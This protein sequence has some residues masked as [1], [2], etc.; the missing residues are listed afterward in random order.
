MTT[1]IFANLYISHSVCMEFFNFFVW[2]CGFIINAEFTQ[3]VFFVFVSIQKEKMLN[4]SVIS[5]S[6]SW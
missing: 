1:I 2:L 5:T 3:D 6:L 4:A